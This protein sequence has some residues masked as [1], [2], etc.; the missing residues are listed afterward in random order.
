MQPLQ[1]LIADDNG[2]V[3]SAVRMLLE[4][5]HDWNVC[6]EAAD[7]IEAVELAEVLKPD[8]I[9]LDI[10]MPQLDGLTAT[11][12]IR[13]RVPDAEIIIL[14][15][16]ESLDLARIAASKGATV[17]IAKANLT[18]DL[19]SVIECMANQHTEVRCEKS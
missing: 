3:R 2:P 11:L 16:H 9:I 1:I 7:G 5:H 10:S 18:T 13:Q 12:L 15:M 4:S 6:G 14:T 17:Y 8:V 19:V